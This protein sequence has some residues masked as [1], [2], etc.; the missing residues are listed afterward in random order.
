MGV[1]STEDMLRWLWDNQFSAVAS[2]MVA[3]ESSPVGRAEINQ[4]TVL[5]QWLLSGWGM[6]IGEILDLEQL[7]EHCRE[8]GRWS[9]FLSS[10]PLKVSLTFGPC[11]RTFIDRLTPVIGTR[12]CGQSSKRCSNIVRDLYMLLLKLGITKNRIFESQSFIERA[13][14]LSFPFASHIRHT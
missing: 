12:R 11:F 6:P 10:M 13:I 3:F 1:E 5:H 2:D 7:A 8:T 14:C 9:F 4:G